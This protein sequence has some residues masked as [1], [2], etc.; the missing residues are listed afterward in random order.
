MPFMLLTSSTQSMSFN[1]HTVYWKQ[2]LAAQGINLMNCCSQSRGLRPSMKNEKS[3][4]VAGKCWD[5]QKAPFS[6]RLSITTPEKR[7]PVSMNLFSERMLWNVL[8]KNRNLLNTNDGNAAQYGGAI[9]PNTIKVTTPA[10][11]MRRQRVV[12]CHK[13]GRTP[14]K[15]SHMVAKYLVIQNSEHW[16]ASGNGLCREESDMQVRETYM[17]D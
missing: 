3:S 12:P 8:P 1:I 4:K 16:I 11:R 9:D 7:A 13:L 15:S 2:A 17:G 10:G 14:L 6:E 5:V